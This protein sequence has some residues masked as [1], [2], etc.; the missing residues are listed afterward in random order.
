MAAMRTYTCRDHKGTF[1]VMPRKGR[2]PVRCTDDNP[3]TRHPE[4]EEV[5]ESYSVSK[6][7]GFR[8]SNTPKAAT[9]KGARKLSTVPEPR[10][11]APKDDMI[12]Q[13]REA[14]KEAIGRLKHLHWEVT[15]QVDYDASFVAVTAVRG[16]ELL[17]MTFSDGECISQDYSLWDVDQPPNCDPESGMPEPDLPFD[18]SEIPDQELVK[19]LAGARVTWWNQLAQREEHAIIGKR[20]SIE[21]IYTGTGDEHPEDRIFKFTDHKGQGFRAFRLGALLTIG[22]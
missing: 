12:L 6:D 11:I 20:V 13:S 8:P 9:A 14:A 4:A 19:H 17:I 18:V 21:H 15:A 5:E 1:E 2:P 7:V 22:Q 16:E 3:C 10:A